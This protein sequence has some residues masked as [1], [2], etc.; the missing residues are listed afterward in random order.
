[1]N[2]RNAMPD[3][4]F[5]AVEHGMSL[6]ENGIPVG[7]L[8][9]MSDQCRSRDLIDASLGYQHVILVALIL[10]GRVYSATLYS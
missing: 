2:C 6:L 3:H 5:C 9:I 8:R 10:D 4:F 1:M 7:I